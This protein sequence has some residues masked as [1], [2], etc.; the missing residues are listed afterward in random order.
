MEK[1]EIT[2]QDIW[3]ASKSKI[4]KNRKKYTRKQKYKKIDNER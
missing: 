3:N 1:I 4:F 2:I